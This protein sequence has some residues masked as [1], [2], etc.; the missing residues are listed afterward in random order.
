MNEEE[1]KKAIETANWEELTQ[2]DLTNDVE[3]GYYYE[4][5][6]LRYIRGLKRAAILGVLNTIYKKV[7]H[8]Q[9]KKG[10]ATNIFLFYEEHKQ[11]DYELSNEQRHIISEWAEAESE[12]PQQQENE[13]PERVRNGLNDNV[14]IEMFDNDK[15]KLKMF[16]LFCEQSKNGE[17]IVKKANQLKLFDN[18]TIKKVHDKIYDLFGNKVT[19]YDNW[20]TYAVRKR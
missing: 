16:L 11:N 9:D 1:R 15:E 18:N 8:Q 3:F 5:L 2:K 20:K 7:Q 17:S 10:F 6:V 4:A 14:L 13:L 19:G 12:Q